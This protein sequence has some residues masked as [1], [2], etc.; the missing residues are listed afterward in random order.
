MKANLLYYRLLIFVI[1]ITGLG[2]AHAHD[3][4]GFDQF[5]SHMMAT[6]PAYVAKQQ[7]LEQIIQ[8]YLQGN[9]NA[10]ITPGG[11]EKPLDIEVTLPVV[12]HIVNTSAG[13]PLIPVSQVDSAMARMN[14]DFRNVAGF[15]P[16][17][18]MRFAL[19]KRDPNGNATTGINYIDGSQLSGYVQYGV[20]YSGNTG[21][22]VMEF[23]QY[24]WPIDQYINVF[25]I[26]RF[27]SANPGTEIVGTIGMNN[28][29]IKSFV[30]SEIYNTFTHEMGHFFNLWHSFS[31]TNICEPNNDCANQGD[32]VCDTPPILPSDNGT[33]SSCVS[34]DATNSTQNFMSYGSTRN[35][36][37]TG[38]KD[39]MR[40]ALYNG[41]YLWKVAT[42][43]SL[44]PVTVGNEVAIDAIENNSDIEI[45]NNT[46]VPQITLR[47]IGVNTLG[48]A[49]VETYIDGVLKGTTNL[50]GLNILKNGT[51]TVNLNSV[52]VTTGTVTISCV[53]T[54][55]NG[56]TGD[57][58]AWNNKIC[59][60]IF[61]RKPYYYIE[62]SS[63]NCLVTG[64]QYYACGSIATVVA[65]VSDTNRYVFSR[66]S[67]NG[68]TVSTV[69]SYSF[70]VT[71]H[72]YLYA[73]TVDRIYSIN[74]LSQ[75][76]AY[77]TVFP[78]SGNGNTYE[79]WVTVNAVGMNGGIFQYWKDETG[80]IVSYSPQYSFF[81][82]R[83]T[84]LT[85][86]FQAPQPVTYTITASSNNTN[87]GT[88]STVGTGT[89]QS[90][91]TVQATEKTGYQ[92]LHWAENGVIVSTSATYSFTVTGNRNL[93]AHFGP[94]AYTITVG[95]EN[96][97][98]GTVSI[99]GI[100][101][102]GSSITVRAIRNSGYQFLHWTENGVIVSTDSIYVFTVTG[103]RNLVAHFTQ[104][105]T[106]I[107]PDRVQTVQVYPN[108]A[109][110]WVTIQ[111]IP[112]QGI[113]TV[114]GID[115]IS[116][117]LPWQERIDVSLLPTGMYIITI[118]S[119]DDVYI[120][121]FI[122]R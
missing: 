63:Q 14:R 28:L 69:R 100:S 79:S 6:N 117:Q 78:S 98:Q 122:K 8:Q 86:Y 64:S 113:I 10:R 92:F 23:G 60:E 18:K 84:T 120:G 39:R 67:E 3:G 106:G 47:N 74:V 114:V 102:Y 29:V 76:T 7:Q 56:V 59:G 90:V 88:V 2:T 1:I 50:S 34:G 72:R 9:P 26:N 108:P 57:Y 107:I 25:I 27:Y 115:G 32:F 38:Q 33:T 109:T 51:K 110:D 121:K 118:V 91:F 112:Q 31:Q 41:S 19:A 87:Y 49:T 80:T 43:E 58:H 44:I 13:S 71:G 48:T 89:A 11:C 65:T 46:F 66:W 16:D 93:V 97:A 95:P 61:F 4:C 104:I 105:T 45:C 37:T 116:Y 30:F 53:I 111:N 75:N 62:G 99:T 40:A 70:T 77:G 85:A 35:R 42:S 103:N 20:A 22:P 119:G 68:T 15:G 21:Y 96:T 83:N 81:L 94:R 52:A 17:T 101:T 55:V 54:K 12:V 73:E 36:F 5:H 82:K 24:N